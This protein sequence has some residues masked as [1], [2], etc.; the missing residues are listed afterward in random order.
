MFWAYFFADLLLLTS[1]GAP[2]LAWR[3]MQHSPASRSTRVRI[4]ALTLLPGLFLAGDFAVPGLRQLLFSLKWSGIEVG[5]DFR[6]VESSLGPPDRIF[7]HGTVWQ[8]SA[9]SNRWPVWVYHAPRHRGFLTVLSPFPYLR[10][11][12]G[13]DNLYDAWEGGLWGLKSDS[14]LLQMGD[15]GRVRRI[16]GWD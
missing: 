3:W 12:C 5:S 7:V 9:R 6:E 10:F 14:F 11:K 16:D 8:G 15:D 2:Y 1:L 13:L 4:L